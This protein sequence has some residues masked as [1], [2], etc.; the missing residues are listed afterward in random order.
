MTRPSSIDC[1]KGRCHPIALL[2]IR[3][4]A[5]RCLN[6]TAAFKGRRTQLEAL[7]VKRLRYLCSETP[8]PKAGKAPENIRPTCGCPKPLHMSCDVLISV[9]E[10]ADAVV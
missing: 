2:P 4:G 10:A 7:K 8:I 3:W 6:C 1:T 5:A 9:E